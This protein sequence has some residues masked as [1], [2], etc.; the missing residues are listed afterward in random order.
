[1]GD[2]MKWDSFYNGG[3]S[4]SLARISGFPSPRVLEPVGG[5]LAV[6]FLKPSS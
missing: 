5:Y 2:S 1:V 6:A 3:E 4:K